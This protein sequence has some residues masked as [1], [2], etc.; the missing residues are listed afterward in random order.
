[1]QYQAAFA[2]RLRG[3][4]ED[5][6][7]GDSTTVT[8]GARYEVEPGFVPQLQVNVNRKAADQGALADSPDSAGT[9]VYLSA[10]ATWTA[11][12]NLQLFA[13]AQLPVQSHLAGIQL[14]PRWTASTGISVGF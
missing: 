8:F 3:A 7:P 14:A 12:R 11:V 13:F 1:M 10:G 9:V 5:F 4:G 6:R 2:Q